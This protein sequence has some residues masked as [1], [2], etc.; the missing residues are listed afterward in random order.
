MFQCC[1]PFLSGGR[2]P[3]PV[4]S[5]ATRA[6]DVK[7][8]VAVAPVPD[9]AAAAREAARAA[10]AAAAEL[11]AV[12]DAYVAL[13]LKANP[14]G[15]PMYGVNP[16]PDEIFD[17][18][19]PTLD[20]RAAE[21]R[22]LHSRAQ[23][24]AAK[25]L[26][27]DTQRG[28][29]ELVR[30]MLETDVVL[31]G[32]Y[33]D[34]IPAT[35]MWGTCSS[36]FEVLVSYHT[37]GSADDAENLKKRLRKCPERF[38]HVV[39]RFREG[40]AKRITLPAE[41]V[42]LLV[43][44]LAKM[45][46]DD[47]AECPFH[48]AFK[49][50]IVDVGLPEDF[51]LETVRESVVPAY[52]SVKEFL[53]T[54]YRPHARANP[55][56]FGMPDSERVYNDLIFFHTTLRLTADEL[57]QKGLDEVARI[58]KRMETIKDRV[59]GGS[60]SDFLAALRNRLMFP[61]LFFES[62]AD[63]VP[64]YQAMIN[65]IDLRMPRY[66]NRFPKFACAVKPMRRE[67]EASA[68]I[69]YYQPGTVDQPGTYLANLQLSMTTSNHRAMA[70]T[71]HEAIPGHHHQVSLALEIPHPHAVHKFVRATAFEEGWGLYAEYLGEEMGMY[72]TQL[73]MF[74]R[75]EFEMFRALRLVVDTGLH[76]KGWSID[77]CVAYM[78]ENLSMSEEELL[79]EVKRYAIMPGQALA[80]KVGELKILELRNK[81]EVA[82]G[83]KF[84][85][86]AFHDVV[87][88]HGSVRLEVLERNVNA[89]ITQKLAASA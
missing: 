10:E 13:R 59:F 15:G 21:L 28:E 48:T 79:R 47:P 57:H 88:D 64:T 12:M 45:V 1:A 26:P 23:G 69:A 55:G 75:L 22:K 52:A 37:I 24:I 85:I 35:Q 46:V 17:V 63:V 78:R 67:A 16:Y 8:P 30:G 58:R 25:H 29:L 27:T 60:F 81:A 83:D 84:D 51:L 44:K 39:E 65:R 74:G 42:D 72:D 54:E 4:T 76:A 2:A 3:K 68:P 49:D 33:A 50:K 61:H 40:V 66:F 73:D 6:V 19:Q 20:A 86:R 14:E 89:W 53:E 87:L 71:L 11:V 41:S 34:Y 32:G 5:T 31:L 38:A 70:L 56:I 77:K 82:L 43:A 18:S 36:L 7:Q 80:Y 62:D 9:P